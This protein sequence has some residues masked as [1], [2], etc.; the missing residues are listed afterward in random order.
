MTETSPETPAGRVLIIAGSDSSGGAGIQADIKACAAFGAYSMTAITALTAQNTLGVHRVEL[1]SP[2]MV[3]AQIDACVE[4]IG[5][6]VI[7]IGM[8]GSEAII[9]AVHAAIEPLDALVVLDPVM[10]STSGDALLEEGAVTLMKELLVPIADLVTPNVPEAEILTGLTVTDTDVLSKAGDAI[11]KMGAYAAL[12]KGG[13]LD[14]KSVVDVLVSEDGASVMTGPRLHTRHTHGTGCTLASA[15]A[16]ALSLGAN[17]DEAV[18]SARDYVFEAIRTAPKL[19]Q[20]NG[21]LNHG[22]A[23]PAGSEDGDGPAPES[24][25]PFAALKS[26]KSE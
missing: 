15:I 12:M 16:A 18:A 21:P 19:G 24:A 25:N 8:L 10:V 6:D 22:L 1:V 11:L 13:H 9:R 14:T 17:L 2:D 5:V 4:D 23:L 20:G 7:K 3:K 26:L